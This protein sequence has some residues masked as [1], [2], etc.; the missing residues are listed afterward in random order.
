MKSSLDNK[1]HTKEGSTFDSH[2][3]ARLMDCIFAVLP[4]VLHPATS[5]GRPDPHG[6]SLYFPNTPGVRSVVIPKTHRGG[7]A[8]AEPDAVLCDLVIAAKKTAKHPDKA[9]KGVART[10]MIL[11]LW[12]R[13]SARAKL[14]PMHG[15]GKI[16]PS[17]ESVRPRTNILSV[18]K[19]CL[20]P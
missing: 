4:A 9:L 18:M 15:T 10:G 20:L 1:I 14:F 5:M 13:S 3:E 8:F 2:E 12:R 16:A 19:L 6:L 17:K 11:G 7:Y